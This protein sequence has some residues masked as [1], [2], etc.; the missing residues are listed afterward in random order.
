MLDA[1]V[2]SLCLYLLGKDPTSVT[3]E[4]IRGRREK[5]GGGGGSRSARGNPTKERMGMRGGN[6][7]VFLC[8]CPIFPQ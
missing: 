1:G 8:M 3:E 7:I 2:F 6:A 4:V 5:R